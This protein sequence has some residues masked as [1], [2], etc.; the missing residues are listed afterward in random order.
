MYLKNTITP[1]EVMLDINFEPGSSVL[2]LTD[3]S[4]RMLASCCI[5]QNLSLLTHLGILTDIRLWGWGTKPLAKFS[6]VSVL[7]IGHLPVFLLQVKRRLDLETDHQYLA[8]SSGPF[9]G[10]GRH[11]GKGA[12][13]SSFL[14]PNWG[15]AVDMVGHYG[16]PV[17]RW[18]GC[19]TGLP[20]AL[21]VGVAQLQ[22]ECF[23]WQTTA[24]EPFCLA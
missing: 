16:A 8:G 5:P 7:V 24:T 6:V 23:G 2:Y 1:R 15:R 11:P 18:N 14:G 12:I 21:E 19:P 17:G 4:G 9:R 10:R 3:L 22:E 20:Q 13:D